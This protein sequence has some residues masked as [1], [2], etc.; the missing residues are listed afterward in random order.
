MFLGQHSA[1]IDDKGRVVLPSSFKKAMGE[2]AKDQVV[3]QMDPFEKCLRIY[4][5]DSFKKEIGNM[6]SGLNPKSPRDSKERIRFFAN[7][8]NAVIAENGRINIPG[9]YINYA[10]IKKGVVFVGMD[11]FIL[12]WSEEEF[13]RWDRENPSYSQM[14]M[15]E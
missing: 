5:S 15:Q 8:M 12:L 6:I 3:L 9:N 2:D 7:V 13:T 11:E 1:A 14:L 4:P 10:G